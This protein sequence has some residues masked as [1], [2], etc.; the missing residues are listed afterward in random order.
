MPRQVAV[1]TLIAVLATGKVLAGL[2]AVL[3]TGKVLAGPRAFRVIDAGS[4]QPLSGVHVV[5]RASTWQSSIPL[6]YPVKVW[7]PSG[8]LTTDQ[9]GVVRFD[10]TSSADDFAFEADG[11]I[12]AHV[13]RHWFRLEISAEPYQTRS[14]VSTANGSVLVPLRKR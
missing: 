4:G 1:V 7:F 6:C 12:T 2:I 9:Q 3:A 8:E 11:Y 10:K 13:S 14:P 5:H